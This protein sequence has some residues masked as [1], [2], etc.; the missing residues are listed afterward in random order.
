VCSIGRAT[1]LRWERGSVLEAG[2]TA[3]AY[4]PAGVRDQ[5]ADMERD[6]FVRGIVEQYKTEIL[7]YVTGLTGGDRQL[8]E[9]IVQETMLRAWRHATQ[10]DPAIG[11]VRGWLLRVA[12][13]LAID[14]YRSTRARPTEVP[15][16]TAGVERFA[17]SDRTDAMLTSIVVREALDALR[18]QQRD[19]I[20]EVY[21]RGR[22]VVEAANLLGVPVGTVKS[23]VF[24]G[25]LALRGL[26]ERE[27]WRD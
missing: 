15:S 21:Y 1:L 23:R 18:P 3:H 14:G 26:L 8:A 16:D 11:S 22:T 17:V 7:A 25:L 12:R 10:I 24:Y 19:A 2:N 9:D 5:S 13:N 27:T 4:R 20:V 6:E